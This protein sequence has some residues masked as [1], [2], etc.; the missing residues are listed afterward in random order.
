MANKIDL[1]KNKVFAV[2][3]SF[4]SDIQH[5]HEQLKRLMEQVEHIVWV[6]NC[7]SVF[8]GGIFGEVIPEKIHPIW[9][10]QNFGIAVAQNIGIKWA[11]EHGASY[12][13]LM[14]DDSLPDLNM[15]ENLFN[16]LITNPEAAA[17]GAFHFDPRREGEGMP[18]HRFKK[19]KFHKLTCFHHNQLLEVDDVIASGCLIPVE[20]LK[21]VGLMREDFFIDWVDTEWC[22]RARANGYKIYGVC[23]ALLEHSLGDKVVKILGREIPVHAP[24]RHYYQSRNLVLTLKSSDISLVFRIFV[25]FRQ[26]KRFL[27]FSILMKNG[28]S[29]FRMWLMGLLDGILGKSGMVEFTEDGGK[30]I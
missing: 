6:D 14:D 11:M 30:I 5:L 28:K 26:M 10:D 7:S 12:I 23:S 18:F 20:V 15:V 29:Y 27:V 2:V 13:L 8:L 24:W 1:E 9:L 16:A 3:V 25:F 4:N 17:A 22:W 19:G 21:K